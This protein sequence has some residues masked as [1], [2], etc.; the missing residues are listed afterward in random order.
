M[1][2]IRCPEC[3]K[4]FSDRAAACPNCGCPTSEALKGT[5]SKEEREEAAGQMLEAVNQALDRARKAGAS[6]EL[7]SKST[8]ELAQGL[9]IDLSSSRAK[10]NVRII[11]HS[12]VSACDTLYNTYQGQIRKLDQTCRPLLEKD[13]GSVAVRAV[14]GAIQWLNDES[15]IENNYAIQFNGFDLGNAVRAKYVPTQESQMIQGIWQAEYLKAPEKEAEEQW[16]RRL[17]EHKRLALSVER[18]TKRTGV[19]ADLQE[20][21]AEAEEERKRNAPSEEEVEEVEARKLSTQN[22]LLKERKKYERVISEWESTCSEIRAKRAAALEQEQKEFSESLK[23][24]AEKT[25]DNSLQAADAEL[26]QAEA[27]LAQ[28][29]ETLKSLGALKIVEKQK[30][31]KRIKEISTEGLPSLE[32]RRRQIEQIYQ[33]AIADIDNRLQNEHSALEGRAAK[34]Y[35]LPE[36][37]RKHRELID[38]END[39]RKARRDERRLRNRS[40]NLTAKQQEWEYE[41]DLILDAIEEN[42]PMSVSDMQEKIPEFEGQAATA[43]SMVCRLLREEGEIEAY[44]VKY[45]TYF[46]FPE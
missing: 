34:R 36:R 13:P 1:A 16:K 42:G 14:L 40:R 6:F 26:A 44:T 46:R 9:T 38:L 24:S 11:V 39:A 10:D 37:P 17:E 33:S 25:R 23:R 27:E 15:E 4:E 22:S 20:R 19:Y 45:K 3:G 43:I 21:R 18:E 29:N 35:P 2:M 5:I 30:L 7:D 12:A 28:A 31:K 41:K 8:K 32:N